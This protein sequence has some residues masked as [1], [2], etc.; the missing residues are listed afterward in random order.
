MGVRT[1]SYGTIWEVRD[2]GNYS[3][4]RLSTSRKN[5]QTGE[6]EQDFGGY[7]RFIG[8]AHKNAASLNERDRIRFGDVEITNNYV[9][10]KNITYTNVACFSFDLADESGRSSGSAAKK[11]AHKSIEE[12]V[13]EED[14]F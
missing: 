8:E 3:D 6:Y 2:K 7:V 9:K 10:E 12:D 4:V 11:P 5:K 14:P 13:D 1:G